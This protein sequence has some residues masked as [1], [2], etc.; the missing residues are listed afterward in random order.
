MLKSTFLLTFFSC[1][2]Y[3]CSAQIVTTQPAA[4]TVDSEVIIFFDATQGTAGLADCNCD[5]YIHTGLITDESS[6][7]SDWQDIA[8][9]WGVANPDWRLQPVDGEEN[10]YSYTFSPDLSTYFDLSGG[11]D[12]QKLAMV[13]RN[14]DGS[15]EGKDV[16]GTDIFIDLFS[17]SVFSATLSAPVEEGDVWP[18]GLPLNVQAGTTQAATLELYDNDQLV[19]TIDNSTALDYEVTYTSASDHELRLEAQTSAGS[20]V[21]R[22]WSFSTALVVE[23]LEPDAGLI[24]ADPGESIDYEAT[25]YLPLDLSVSFGGNT[26]TIPGGT[27][28]S[29]LNAPTENSITQLIVSAT[30]EGVTAADTL[31][32]VVGGPTFQPAPGGFPRGITVTGPNSVHLQLYAP[33]K[34]DVFVIGNF[35]NWQPTVASRMK[36][37][38]DAGTFWID[39]EN[40]QVED[41]LFQYLV[42]Y[43]MQTADPHSTLVLD[44]FNDPFIGE[45]TF[46]GIPDYPLGG[47]GIVSWVRMNPPEYEWQVNDFV[48]VDEEDLVV[49]ELLVRD[50]IDEHSFS[51]LTDTLDYLVRLGVNAVEL[52]PVN[53][54]EGNI[55]WGY[56]PSF[57]MALDKYYGSPEDFKALV[58]ACHEKGLAVIVDV[59]FNHAFSQ[60]PLAQLWWNP[61]EFR[62]TEDSPYLNVEAKH[63]FN[64]GYDFNHE[65]P[66]TRRYVKRAIRY[67]IEEY[68]VD[69]YRFDLSKGFTQ[70]ENPNN[71]GAWNQ[72]DA[73]RIAI[74][75]DYADELWSVNPDAYMIMEHLAEPQEEEELAQYGQGMYFWSGFVPHDNYMQSA[76]GYPS[77]NDLSSGLSENRGFTGN[78][79]I[80]YIE[81]HD[82]ERLVYKTTEFGNSSGSYNTQELSTGL[83]RSELAAVFFYTLP[84]PK[85]LWQFG[86]LGYDFS[87]NQCPGGG[88]NNDCRTDPKPIRWDYRN[89]AD[90]QDVYNTIRSLLF[91]RNNYGTFHTDNIDYQLDGL[92]KRIHLEHPD[93]D[94]AVLGNFDV[95]TRQ[96][97]NP[98][99]SAGTWYDYFTGESLEITNPN[100][101]RSLVPGEYRLYLSEP[102]DRPADGLSPSSIE[103]VSPETFGLVLSPNPTDGPL[104][105]TFKLDRAA[106]VDIQVLDLTG[107]ILDYSYAGQ[108]LT[109]DTTMDMDLDLPGGSYLLRFAADER[110]VVMPFVIH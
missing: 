26:S 73:S 77:N 38:T 46:A 36:R 82:E 32:I 105:L 15:L 16:G 37:G 55:S 54:F 24:P 74:I 3:L 64:V 27:T 109:S 110:A 8:T 30:H 108:V 20:S 12:V 41:L 68:R 51:V 71:V 84:G 53:E 67:F 81:S 95:V 40:I 39:L 50:F 102:I 28:T 89:D 75:K 1:F 76:M 79:L 18:L 87:I 35:S 90:R 103:I 48:P 5:V 45:E 13:F 11:E 6:N 9:M 42:D 88:I 4:P 33:G 78:N 14:G 83:D 2:A 31:A 69:G 104:R 57:H 10:L 62:P 101:S 22:T 34:D 17:S 92:V 96:I 23:F 61:Q 93:F 107:R 66:H 91:L 21:V 85:M 63:P 43:E 29:S 47:E 19:A 59:V 94:A 25:S 44:P 72:Y 52:M 70:T 98:F 97:D 106:Y 86:E 80:S 58:D 60:S 65:S 49:Y 100:A 99:P 7:P 56:N